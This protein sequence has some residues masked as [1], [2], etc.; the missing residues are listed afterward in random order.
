MC[1][2]LSMYVCECVCARRSAYCVS[3]A[4]GRQEMPFGD[5]SGISMTLRKLYVFVVTK[6]ASK[7][8][9]HP[10]FSPSAA[11]HSLPTIDLEVEHCPVDALN[12]VARCV[13]CAL[14]AFIV[15]WKFVLHVDFSNVGLF[16][17]YAYILVLAYIRHSNWNIS[18]V[19]DNRFWS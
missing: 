10:L 3:T 4:Y 14:Y 11:R 13:W 17:K 1:V 12:C 19:V 8:R 15:M 5:N 2:G 9:E 6:T 7:K 18:G 16:C